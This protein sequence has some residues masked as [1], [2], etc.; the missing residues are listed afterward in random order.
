LRNKII[1]ISLLLGL[2]VCFASASEENVL[3]AHDASEDPNTTAVMPQAPPPGESQ[4][5]WNEQVEHC[6]DIGA[7]MERRQN[8]PLDQTP[9]AAT[10]S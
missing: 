4:E 3:W 1:P 6:K 8:L 2:C 10:H 7:E 5:E 9:R